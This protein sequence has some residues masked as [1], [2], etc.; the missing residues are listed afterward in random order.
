MKDYDLDSLEKALEISEEDAVSG[1][2]VHDQLKLQLEQ[3]LNGLAEREAG[4]IRLRFGLEDGQPKTLGEI[5]EVYGVTRERIRQIEAAV[6]K[7]L[8][9]PARSQVIRDYLDD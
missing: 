8:R 3:I 6:M 1:A 5:A 4:I 7:K 9:H 2:V